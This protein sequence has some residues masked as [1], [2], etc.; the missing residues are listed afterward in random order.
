MWHTAKYSEFVLCIYPCLKCTHTAVNTHTPWT[1]TQSS[2]QPF[3]LRCPG[4]SWGFSA[5]LQG[6]SL[7]Y[8]GWRE[9]STFTSPHQFLPAWD[10]NSQPLDYESDSLIIRPRLPFKIPC[11]IEC[12]NC[13]FFGINWNLWAISELIKIN[14]IKIPKKERKNNNNCLKKLYCDQL[15]DTNLFYQAKSITGD[16]FLQ[17]HWKDRN[18]SLAL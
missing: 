6:T 8:W 9:C 14:K 10:S 17:C 1:H 5:L 7:W 13:N 12:V 16:I 15:N 2:G 11:L 3:V 4:S 18:A